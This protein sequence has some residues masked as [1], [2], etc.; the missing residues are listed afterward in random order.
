MSSKASSDLLR[1]PRRSE[2]HAFR[3]RGDPFLSSADSFSG[4]TAFLNFGPVVDRGRAVT[5]LGASVVNPGVVLT[6]WIFIT[7]AFLCVTIH[8]GFDAVS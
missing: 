5:T 3:R 4:A 2:D 7:D 1:F 6:A 8:V